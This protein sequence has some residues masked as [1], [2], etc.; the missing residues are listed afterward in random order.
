MFSARKLPPQFTTTLLCFPPDNSHLKVSRPN[1]CVMCFPLNFSNLK[2]SRSISLT[3]S[4]P[5]KI[6]CHAFSAQKIPPEF[7]TLL[8]FPPDNSHLRFPCQI[9]CDMCFPL[10]FSHLKVP[11]SISLSLKFPAQIFV[12]CLFCPKIVC[13]IY[14]IVVFSTRQFSPTVSHPNFCAMC[15]PLNF[16]HLKF[17]RLISLP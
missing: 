1:F 3:K 10:N 13:S 2:V 16:S 8:C 15:F 5:P 4:F 6:L 7:T 14:Y 11:C 12:P 9:F 17:Y